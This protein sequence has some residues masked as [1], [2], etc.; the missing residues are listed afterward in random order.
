MLLD[1]SRA[2]QP[3][4]DDQQNAGDSVQGGVDGWEIVKS[5]K[6]LRLYVLSQI[7]VIQM[8]GR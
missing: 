5:Q 6:G 4:A 3:V 8:S 2:Y 7:I 1:S